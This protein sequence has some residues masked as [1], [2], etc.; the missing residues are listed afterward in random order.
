VL[1]E[2]RN[3]S[4][5]PPEASVDADD[6]GEALLLFAGPD[7]AQM[8]V[9]LSQVKRLEAFSRASIEVVGSRAVVQ[10]FDDI[11]PLADVGSLLSG[12]CVGSRPSLDAS[13]EPL[14]ALVY[15]KNGRHVGV[16]VDRILDTIEQSLAAVSAS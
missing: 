14:Q 15:S 5:L 4:S 11:L 10:Y 6:T 7:A 2:V 3:R 12:G 9:R 8:A 13:D 1:S 16:I